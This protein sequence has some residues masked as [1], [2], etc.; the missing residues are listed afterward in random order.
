MRTPI[1]FCHFGNSNY[2]PYVLEV[3]RLFNPE[4]EIFFLG[5][6]TNKW[7]EK[8]I[9]I[10]HLFFAKYDYG[11]EIETFNR[12][13]RLVQGKKHRHIRHGKDWVYFVFK[14]WSIYTTFWL[15]RE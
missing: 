13:Y 14:R 4:K 7:L 2:L 6:Q 12:V 9:R 10:R 8:K 15:S 3:A 11:K 5:D 1:I